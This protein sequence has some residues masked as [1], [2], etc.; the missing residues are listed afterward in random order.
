VTIQ[1]VSS[2]YWSQATFNLLNGQVPDEDKLIQAGLVEPDQAKRAAIIKQYLQ[3]GMDT[4]VAQPF[5]SIAMQIG[6]GPNV[7][8]T[9]PPAAISIVFFADQVKHHTASK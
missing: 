5:N 2:Y 6:M 1:A 7:D 9:L 4:W 8:V 3:I